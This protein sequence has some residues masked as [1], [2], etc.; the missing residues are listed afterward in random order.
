VLPTSGNV[1]L[2]VRN[3]DKEA[4]IPA[5]KMLVEEGFKILATQG[6]C[7]ALARH[8]IPAT[9]VS[10]LAEG[11][12]NVKDL[13]KNGQIQL[14]INTP[15]KKGPQT[16]EGQIRAMSVLNKLPIV[17]TI[18]GANAAA[19]AIRQ[20]QKENWSVRPLQDYKK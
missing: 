4:I 7:D 18:T 11:R 14:I 20:L 19:R 16:D 5:A 12:P 3:E 10:K 2:S 9:R 13:I 1:F 17:T 15:T 6:T 8:G